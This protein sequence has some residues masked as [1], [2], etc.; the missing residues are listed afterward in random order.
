MYMLIPTGLERNTVS[1]YYDDMLAHV[2]AKLAK[3]LVEYQTDEIDSTGLVYLTQ[4]ETEAVL[5]L[6][7]IALDPPQVGSRLGTHPV[8]EG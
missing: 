7:D 1:I 4:K 2:R 6:V 8:E 3:E 5:H